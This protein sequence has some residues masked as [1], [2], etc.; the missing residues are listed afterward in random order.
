M[1]FAFTSMVRRTAGAIAGFLALS[2]IVEPALTDSFHWLRGVTPMYAL[3]STTV[4][5]FATGGG[6]AGFST[7]GHSALVLAIWAIVLF[8]LCGDIFVR[9]EVR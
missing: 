2:F 9:R 8:L 6:F 5:R 3:V 1:G 7:L 4:N